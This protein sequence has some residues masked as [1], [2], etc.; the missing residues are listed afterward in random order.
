MNSYAPYGLSVLDAGGR[1]RLIDMESGAEI[2]SAYAG[3]GATFAAYCGMIIDDAFLAGRKLI[4]AAQ[5]AAGYLFAVADG[6]KAT[7]YEST[8]KKLCEAPLNGP[9]EAFFTKTAV[10]ISPMHGIP[11]VY[12]LKNGQKIVDLEKDAYLTYITEMGDYIVSQ[13]LSAAGEHFGVLLNSAFQPI[14]SLPSRSCPADR[15]CGWRLSTVISSIRN[16][17]IIPILQLSRESMW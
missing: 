4:G 14:A 10:I 13:Y 8:G 12:S 1:L 7:V 9:A 17:E 6:E 15:R 11:A 2:F 16:R 5:T 3:Q